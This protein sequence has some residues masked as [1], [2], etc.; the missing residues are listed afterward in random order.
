MLLKNVVKEGDETTPRSTEDSGGAACHVR[1]G[2]KRPVCVRMRGE[3]AASESDQPDRTCTEYSRR[4]YK[5]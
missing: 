4:T 1:A 3:Q 5:N 2:W